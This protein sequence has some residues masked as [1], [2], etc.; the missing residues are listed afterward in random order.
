[1]RE[2]PFKFIEAVVPDHE[3][4][5][6]GAGVLDLHLGTQFVGQLALQSLDVG[7]PPR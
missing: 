4:A 2:N 6:A 1:M 3:L 5:A 7:I